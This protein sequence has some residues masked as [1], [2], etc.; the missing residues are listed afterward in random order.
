MVPACSLF[1][2]ARDAKARMNQEGI[3]K[4][5]GSRKSCLL[6]IILKTYGLEPAIGIERERE[7]EWV[8]ERERRR[9][10]KRGK[11]KGK[12]RKGEGKR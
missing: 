8:R 11:E 7:R 10:G 2:S 6:I 4:V 3:G 12:R 5:E 1:I 9:K